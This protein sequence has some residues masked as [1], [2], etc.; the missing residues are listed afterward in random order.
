MRQCSMICN[1]NVLLEI[2]WRHEFVAKC[3]MSVFMYQTQQVQQQEQLVWIKINSVAET[4]Q[5]TSIFH[6][7]PVSLYL[8]A[9][10]PNC[11]QAEQKTYTTGDALSSLSNTVQDVRVHTKLVYSS[12]GVFDSMRYPFRLQ[13]SATKSTRG[14]LVTVLSVVFPACPLKLGVFVMLCR[15]FMCNYCMHLF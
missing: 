9:C 11:S 5:E 2:H 10:Q 3:I 13:L 6:L 8:A 4:P 12:C 7:R 15:G 1:G 14:S